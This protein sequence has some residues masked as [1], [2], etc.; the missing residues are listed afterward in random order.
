MPGITGRK[1]LN[2][3]SVSGALHV[4]NTYKSSPSDTSEQHLI[5][6]IERHVILINPEL[7]LIDDDDDDDDDN[8]NNTNTFQS[9]VTKAAELIMGSS[10]SSSIPAV[11][12]SKERRWASKRVIREYCDAASDKSLWTEKLTEWSRTRPVLS[13]SSSSYTNS[14]ELD[15][16][17]ALRLW[18][19]D[20]EDALS[21]LE[22]VF[23]AV[24]EEKDGWHL[25][26]MIGSTL[27]GH[28]KDQ[29][30]Q[31]KKPR[32]NLSFNLMRSI[33]NLTSLIDETLAQ[34]VPDPQFI[35]GE[36][37][38]LSS[39]DLLKV[40]FAVS[41]R[42]KMSRIL[43]QIYSRFQISINRMGNIHE[44]GFSTAVLDAGNQV[45]MNQITLDMVN[46]FT[47]HLPIPAASQIDNDDELRCLIKLIRE[48]SN[49]LW[50]SPDH[51]D[52]NPLFE[53][54]YTLSLT[55][56]IALDFYVPKV[57]PDTI[58]L[59][60]NVIF[61]RYNCSLARIAH[62]NKLFDIL[63]IGQQG[64][65]WKHEGLRALVVLSFSHW[66]SGIFRSNYQDL[67]SQAQTDVKICINEFVS[68][69]LDTPG[70][71]IHMLS[72]T[73]TS[74]SFAK[75]PVHIRVKFTLLIHHVSK[76]LVGLACSHDQQITVKETVF[77]TR[78]SP[79]ATYEGSPR[80]AHIGVPALSDLPDCIEDLLT[81][82]AQLAR[83]MPHLSCRY[84][85][86]RGSATEPY[87]PPTLIGVDVRQ[88]DRES[89]LEI[90]D[91]GWGIGVNQNQL[92]QPM[93]IV[94]QNNF[95]PFQHLP[96][97]Q[98]E[99]NQPIRHLDPTAYLRII[100]KLVH[101]DLEDARHYRPKIDRNRGERN[102]TEMELVTGGGEIQID[103]MENPS[104]NVNCVRIK[105]A[106]VKSF[107]SLFADFLAAL[108][109]GPLCADGR[110][111]PEHLAIFLGRKEPIIVSTD[112]VDDSAQNSNI[113]SKD[114]CLSYP[115]G[116]VTMISLFNSELDVKQQFN[117]EKRYEHLR[118]EWEHGRSA[119]EN[120]ALRDVFNQKRTDEP[121]RPDIRRPPERVLQSVLRVIQTLCLDDRIRNDL[122]ER[123]VKLP[124]RC[125][126]GRFPD[127]TMPEQYF[128]GGS[129]MDV[130]SVDQNV[131][132]T[133]L[134]DELLRIL[135]LGSGLGVKSKAAVMTALTRIAEGSPPYAARIRDGLEFSGLLRTNS[136]IGPD[137]RLELETVATTDMTYDAT[138]SFCEL[139]RTIISQVP[140][141]SLGRGHRCP[142]IIPHLRFMIEDVLLQHARRPVRPGCDADRWK[143]AF[144]P[145]SIVF[146]LLRSYTVNFPVSKSAADAADVARR[147]NLHI[148]TSSIQLGEDPIEIPEMARVKGISG[149]ALYA[150]QFRE[151]PLSF[152]A[153]KGFIN[154][155]C[156][157]SNHRIATLAEVCSY[158]SPI[159]PSARGGGR[160]RG[161]TSSDVSSGL[162]QICWYNAITNPEEPVATGIA[163]QESS[164][165]WFLFETSVEQ[166]RFQGSDFFKIL[167]EQGI[168]VN[169]EDNN[170]SYVP[171][172]P[173]FDFCPVL[174]KLA[175]RHGPSTSLSEIEAPRSA[176]FE[177]MRRLL[178]GG[179]LFR[180]IL[181]IIVQAGCEGPG[182]A[183]GSAGLEFASE[184]RDITSIQS[185][186]ARHKALINEMKN[187]QEL[188]QS[189]SLFRRMRAPDALVTGNEK[190]L[191][192]LSKASE[193]VADEISSRNIISGIIGVPNS[194][195]DVVEWREKVLCLALSVLDA[196]LSRDELFVQGCRDPVALPDSLFTLPTLLCRVP[197]L[198]YILRAVAYKYDSRISIVAARILYK[199]EIERSHELPIGT[200][201]SEI[202]QSSFSSGD[203]PTTTKGL[204]AYELLETLAVNVV[205]ES[206]MN[207]HSLDDERLVQMEQGKK[208]NLVDPLLSACRKRQKGVALRLIL[209]GA[210]VEATDE[211]DGATP[212]LLS[213][214]NRLTTI[215]NLL[216]KQG[217]VNLDVSDRSNVSPL[218]ETS[219]AG[220][221]WDNTLLLRLIEYGANVD[222]R[223]VYGN[224]LLIKSLDDIFKIFETAYNNGNNLPEDS[225][226]EK[227]KFIAYLVYKE[228]DI[229]AENEEG[230]SVQT[231]L[232]RLVELF[233]IVQSSNTSSQTLKKIA[234]ENKWPNF[235]AIK[236]T[237]D[238]EIR[239]RLFDNDFDP[240]KIPEKVKERTR[241]VLRLPASTVLP[242]VIISGICLPISRLDGAFGTRHFTDG[243]GWASDKSTDREDNVKGK[244]L[245]RNIL[246]DLILRSIQQ[247]LSATSIGHLLLGLHRN[248]VT[249][250]R[251][252][253]ITTFSIMAKILKDVNF[254]STLQPKVSATFFG[255]FHALF[256]NPLTAMQTARYLEEAF[257]YFKPIQDGGILTWAPG[258][259]VLRS[260]DND[261]YEVLGQGDVEQRFRIRNLR[262]GALIM[263]IDG[264]E[265]RSAFETTEKMFLPWILSQLPLPLDVQSRGDPRDSISL[266]PGG[267]GS[268]DDFFS[269]RNQHE[270]AYKLA[271][272][273][274]MNSISCEI[275]L[276]ASKPSPESFLKLR[277]TCTTLLSLSRNGTSF[278]RRILSWMSNLV[279]ETLPENIA[280]YQLITSIA[281]SEL[282][283]TSFAKSESPLFTEIQLF[284]QGPQMQ[285]CNIPI[286]KALLLSRNAAISLN[287]GSIKNK[288]FNQIDILDVL[289]WAVHQND[290]CNSLRATCTFV[291]AFARMF[292]AILNFIY[293]DPDTTMR[294]EM[295]SKEKQFLIQNDL[296]EL[297][298]EVFDAILSGV[299]FNIESTSSSSNFFILLPLA[300]IVLNI[301]HKLRTVCS[302]IRT[303]SQ[304]IKRLIEELSKC[305]IASSKSNHN[306][307]DSSSDQFR[308]LIYACLLEL[309]HY[310]MC[311]QP[312]YD[313]NINGTLLPSQI[314]QCVVQSSSL[315][316]TTRKESILAWVKAFGSLTSTTGS[317]L[318]VLIANDCCNHT[319][320]WRSLSFVLLATLFEPPVSS[321]ETSLGGIPHVLWLTNQISSDSDI[322]NDVYTQLVIVQSQFGQEVTLSGCVPKLVTSLAFLDEAESRSRVSLLS[323]GKESRF[324]TNESKESLSDFGFSRSYDICLEALTSFAS[325]NSLGIISLI[326]YGLLDALLLLSWPKNL[327]VEFGELRSKA[328]GLRGSSSIDNVIANAI[329]YIS[330]RLI[331]ILNLLVISFE[332]RPNE[333]SVASKILLWLT[334]NYVLLDLVIQ[335]SLAPQTNLSCLSLSRLFVDLLK[336]LVSVPNLLLKS[337]L[338]NV[339]VVLDESRADEII[340]RLFQRYAPQ[341]REPNVQR[342]VSE[343]KRADLLAA[344]H[345][346]LALDPSRRLRDVLPHSDEFLKSWLQ[347]VSPSTLEEQAWSSSNIDPSSA[348]FI[349]SL[350]TNCFHVHVLL[351][352]ERLFNTLAGFCRVRSASTL[353]GLLGSAR[354]ISSVILFRSK[355]HVLGDALRLASTP[356]ITALVEAI[357]HAG[358]AYEHAKNR[359]E[360]ASQCSQQTHM[361]RRTKF[362]PIEPVCL[363]ELGS[364][365]NAEKIS[366]ESKF[367]AL[368]TFE[369]LLVVLLA[370][371][372]SA[373]DLRLSNVTEL[374]KFQ[375]RVQVAYEASPFAEM[376]FDRLYGLFFVN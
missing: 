70:K 178:S 232:Q 316:L 133:R 38:S 307:D 344:Q 351:A 298:G 264:Y 372:L 126:D 265:L 97:M 371:S 77:R 187:S 243:F 11:V 67:V 209:R 341:P 257:R 152:Q 91:P 202:L 292:C 89:G 7:S 216:I 205:S 193:K 185:I 192:D 176:N 230:I 317:S 166:S 282:N 256:K 338:T 189:D 339:S 27:L 149:W 120:D 68:Y 48:Q 346:A 96:M 5:E 23:N 47:T 331:S 218:Q 93:F 311:R 345:Q 305:A 238:T 144:G 329:A 342:I 146:D 153:M 171:G 51:S 20:R 142:G 117:R 315:S 354:A 236:Q 39:D 123:M 240:I 366:N 359:S 118:I 165:I 245:R 104:A 286:L 259:H 323:F 253:Y 291:T 368:G 254:V 332:A 226:A 167:I 111:C 348:L 363:Q 25:T 196:A 150:V 163:G 211:I 134:L 261:T 44:R 318:A 313:F 268:S 65:N 36:E 136:S 6:E 320:Q 76:E 281:Q 294:N 41:H 124:D 132:T 328:L 237:S 183:E 175:I 3:C 161:W 156:G 206:S 190:S 160:F 198:P 112:G 217:R 52:A 81:L 164:S 179:D 300:E 61:G 107:L 114:S 71:A 334:Q 30:L 74:P 105:R 130:D 197:I 53:L 184:I 82:Q 208:K 138:L 350:V 143:M 35:G 260:E 54:C 287:S 361:F 325:S 145:L 137:I 314:P 373:T 60:S 92:E 72:R 16:S 322:L 180:C 302:S 85:C 109:S 234:N 224:T 312:M 62:E 55:L 244:S 140:T 40:S 122:C 239:A 285:L 66:Y 283:G 83:A 251:L 277:A 177:V 100:V 248:L 212:L 102:F 1:C 56:T 131:Q 108:G 33:M 335:A 113:F 13:L 78:M 319:I 221:S 46:A 181:S 80:P 358:L 369:N 135:P 249:K 148:I 215:A 271:V 172:H 295:I 263:S 252:S 43:F 168:F 49:C 324:I 303:R 103:E 90:Y 272:S 155:F 267:S 275:H 2:V 75:L 121:K 266:R 45:P 231:C 125:V 141:H 280:K 246:L 278:V 199:L 367:L 227:R 340:L 308:A 139:M 376:I 262:T 186:F 19:S 170:P 293:P 304:D 88:I 21:F 159:S 10:S 101:D 174:P 330:P 336:R 296:L 337:S 276:Q 273:E 357:C 9:D 79:L 297:L 255:I 194:S 4:L 219:S 343:G 17:F 42:A 24:D 213:C 250:G 269:A 15:A 309:T 115:D 116:L 306:V 222:C 362:H 59:F 99:D 32:T 191:R 31:I 34:A 22:A 225:I 327:I 321:S 195:E 119:H 326:D 28:Y 355:E 12:G 58:D 69:A 200:L 284:H 158:M 26:A 204:S 288:N 8:N 173:H 242:D 360:Y 94:P 110:S 270:Q 73:L 214:R 188:F 374:G 290:T 63:Q 364:P 223:D 353:P 241:T 310:A 333:V 37:R 29:G 64:S 228:A 129:F 169:E 14:I 128:V 375:S 347:A 301:L 18:L 162:G 352:G 279:Q 349:D 229:F 157:E 210:D 86:L 151:G 95:Q 127:R 370:H 106:A 84:W 147:L 203:G 182:S 247:D 356:T 365:I 258:H 220:L 57:D 299:N 235:D 274:L 98:L 50:R 154:Q 289:N 233:R 207:V 201:S 87:N